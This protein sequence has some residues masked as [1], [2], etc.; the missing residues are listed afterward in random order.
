MRVSEVS[1]FNGA[2]ESGAKILEEMLTY[3][4]SLRVLEFQK[5]GLHHLHEKDKSTFTGSGW[6]A[7]GAEGAKDAQAVTPVLVTLALLTRSIL[8]DKAEIKNIGIAETP[9]MFKTRYVRKQRDLAVQVAIEFEAGLINGINASNQMLGLFTLIKDAA[10]GGQTSALDFTTAELA[11]MNKNVGLTISSDENTD[12]LIEQI[13]Y[14]KNIV[15][16]ANLILAPS[17]VKN[18]LTTRANNIHNLGV[19]KD[20]FGS[21]IDVV[22]G[23]PI[24]GLDSHAMPMTQTSGENDDCGS[25]LVMRTNESFGVSIGTNMGF[26][27]EDFTYLESIPSGKSRIDLSGNL[28]VPRTNNVF[29]LS[30]IRLGGA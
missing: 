7:I 19:S 15:K 30:G 13:R 29:R 26:D 12:M 18:R 28:L 6:R 3:A 20:L 23:L 8:V 17:D 22:A 4:P 11:A 5:V 16:G 14:A 9:E 24:V 10:A 21:E 25:I 1:N 27:F 2:E